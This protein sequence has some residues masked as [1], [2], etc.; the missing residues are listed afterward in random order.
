MIK[1]DL[2]RIVIDEMISKQ[3]RKIYATNKIVYIH[4]DEIWSFDLSD[5]DDYKTA[6]TRGYRYILVVIDNFSKSDWS[7]PPKSK[8]SQTIT[9]EFSNF[10]STSKRKHNKIG[11]HR[12]KEFHNYIFENFMK[13]KNIQLFPRSS[14]KGPSILERFDRTIR[15]LLKEPVFQRSDANC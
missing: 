11:K 4:I 8:N 6:K 2:F 9:D 12:G 10:L 7:V 1:K 5:S 15:D 13:I 14:D 3:R